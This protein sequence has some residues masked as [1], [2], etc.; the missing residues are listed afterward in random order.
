MT[1]FATFW[2]GS[3]PALVRACLSSF[4]ARGAQLA[5]Y[6]YE[7]LELPT[8][9][10]RRDAREIVADPAMAERYR[11]GGRQSAA[12]FAD[13]FRY[14]LLERADVCWVDADMV[15][16][17]PVDPSAPVIWGRQPKAKGKA[18][19]NNAVLRLPSGH[20]VLSDMLARA[21]AAEG[22]EIGWGAIGPYLLTEIAEAHGVEA[23]ASPPSRFFP[24]APDD[25]WRL[26]D[27]ASRAAVADAA[28][29]ADM[30]HLW[31]ELLRRMGW[32]FDAAPPAGSYL[33]EIFAGAAFP[34]RASAQDIE[35]LAARWLA[36]DS[37]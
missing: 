9:V 33:A 29:S 24:V 19:I 5:L 28:A 36:G 37:K 13:R 32:D 35:A 4:P 23:T 14:E 18:L 7:P 31:S 17:R 1:V 10:E 2:R 26:F 8:G 27:P 15:M 12:T 21:R 34:R 22:V 16:L 11:V 25:F 30:L 3:L 6:T 20:P